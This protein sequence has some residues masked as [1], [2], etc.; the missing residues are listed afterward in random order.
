[1]SKKYEQYV[2]SKAARPP[3]LYETAAAGFSTQPALIFLNGDKPIKTNQFLEVTWV[4]GDGV[5][6]ATPPWSTHKHDYEEL[7]LFLSSDHT[8][9][10]GDLGAEVEFTMGDKDDM[11]KYSFNTPTTIFVPKG[12]YHLPIYFKNVRKPFAVVLMGINV[13]SVYKA[14]K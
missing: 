7:F 14:I 10:D 12:V 8:N 11:E 4:F 1:M 2:V 5:G 3:H 6:G 13:G 9:P